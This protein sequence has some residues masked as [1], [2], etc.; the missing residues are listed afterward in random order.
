MSTPAPDVPAPTHSP[1]THMREI[2][3][4][5]HSHLFY[6]WPVWLFGFVF[7]LWTLVENDR[8]AVLPSNAELVISKEPGVKTAIYIDGDMHESTKII[9]PVEA[10]GNKYHFIPRVSNKSWMGPLY[11]I[12][13]CLVII[14]TNVPLRGLWSLVAV[15]LCVTGSLFIS[16]FGWWDNI[17]SALYGLHIFIN[18]AGYLMLGTVVFGGW[19]LATFVFD[20]R[21]YIIFMPGQIRVCEQIGGREKVYDTMGMTVEKHRDDWFRHIFLGFGSG[22]LSVRTAGADRHEILMPNVALIGFK[23]GPIEQLLRERQTVKLSD[24][25]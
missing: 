19:A 9:T 21:S 5:S 7:A 17:F 4:V 20:N 14:I 22:D 13:L 15:I 23:I 24:S 3:I 6:W 2:R 8:L 12:I 25:Q 1:Q 18:M 16:L 10:G 11:L